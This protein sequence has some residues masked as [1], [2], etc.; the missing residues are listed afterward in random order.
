MKIIPVIDLK[1]GLVVHAQ[2]GLR[3]QYQPIHTPLC[4]SADLFQVMS[5]FLTLADFDCF[6][7]A[8]LNAITGLG[9][10]EALI[11]KLL[12]TYPQ[13]TFWIDSGYQTF[14]NYADNHLPVLGSECFSEDQIVELKAF[15]KCFI[16]SLDYGKSG[17]LGATSLFSDQNLWPETIIIMTL[18][19]VGSQQGPDIET[20]MA[21]CKRYP[22]K[23][24]VAAGGIRNIEDLQ[25]LTQI[26]IHQALLAS[27]LHSRDIGQQ[28]LN[29]LYPIC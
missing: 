18:N 7:I 15:K 2:M 8:D 16:L 26:G 21:F 29:T 24:F 12:K 14:K 4:Q 13:K 28:E 5:A 10:H 1:D 17:A 19:R 3:D 22:E 20:L 25:V 6:Y 11:A 23:N 9:H 27:A